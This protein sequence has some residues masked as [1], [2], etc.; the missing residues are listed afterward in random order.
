M[1]CD[2]LVSS[3]GK[4][5][6][7]LRNQSRNND[8]RPGVFMFVFILMPNDFV[9]CFTNYNYTWISHRIHLE[10]LTCFAPIHRVC[11]NTEL[12][13]LVSFRIFLAILA[14][15]DFYFFIYETMEFGQNR[16]Q[17]TF[18]IYVSIRRYSQGHGPW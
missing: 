18:Y 12:V 16:I 4:I 9:V 17:Q 11:L 5:Y 3:L 10:F 6:I 13:K 15:V 8:H 14:L 1:F 7:I 2:Y